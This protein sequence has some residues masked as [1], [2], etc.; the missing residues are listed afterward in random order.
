MGSGLA[1]SLELQGPLPCP[2]AQAHN[3]TTLFS[4]EAWKP[5]QEACDPQQAL[6]AEAVAGPP[7]LT[8]GP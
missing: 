6:Q 5:R 3:G 4:Q 2:P 8:S 1:P 7:L